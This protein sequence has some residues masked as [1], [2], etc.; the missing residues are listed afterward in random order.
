MKAQ[1]ADIIGMA[2]CCGLVGERDRHPGADRA[3]M[4]RREQRWRRCTAIAGITARQ[5]DTSKRRPA[6]RP[7]GVRRRG[8]PLGQPRLQCRGTGECAC[9]STP[10]GNRYGGVPQAPRFFVRPG[11]LS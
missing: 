8:D 10:D 4:N 11:S 1:R 3:M 2:Q 5:D 9:A 7:F 6:A